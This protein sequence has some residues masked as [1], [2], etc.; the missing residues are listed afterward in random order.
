METYLGAQGPKSTFNSSN[1]SFQPLH[2]HNLR[3]RVG[4]DQNPAADGGRCRHHAVA[5]RRVNSELTT[6]RN[7]MKN[8]PANRSTFEVQIIGSKPT[9][10]LG[11]PKNILFWLTS[12]DRTHCSQ[13]PASLVMG[14]S[15]LRIGGSDLGSCVLITERTV[16][17][18]F[19]SLTLCYLGQIEDTSVRLA[20]D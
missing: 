12:D 20:T 2:L 4:A 1:S 15:E 6:T 3:Q 5:T 14:S 13:R 16:S 10:E 7:L 17:W 9:F 19:L 8:W 11:V 18:R